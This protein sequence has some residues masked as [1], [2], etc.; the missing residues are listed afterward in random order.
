MMKSLTV[1][2][3]E[4]AL[5][6]AVKAFLERLG[7]TVKG[8]VRGCDIVAVREGEPPLLVITELKLGLSMELLLQAVDRMP[9][10]DEVWLAVPATRRGRDRDVRAHRLCKLLGFG[11]LAV[12]LRSGQVEIVVE[13]APYKPRQS[14]KKR[15]LL[16]QE[17]RRRRGDPAIGG[18]SRRPIMTAYRQQAL[19]CADA[20]RDSTKRPIEL[21]PI[22]PDAAKILRDNYYGWF[23]RVTRGVYQ[24]ATPGREALITYAAHVCR[25]P[26]PIPNGSN[27]A[28]DRR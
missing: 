26:Q 5:Y 24:L 27:V 13:A 20:L 12:N 22:A 18:S 9:S 6:P 10:A 4:T 1:A 16:L 15:G 23:E 28:T 7:F 3:T 14:V 8:E 25:E 17:F 19:T 2:R 11:L 21:R